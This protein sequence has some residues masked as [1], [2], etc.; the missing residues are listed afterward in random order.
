MM[1]RPPRIRQTRPHPPTSCL[2]CTGRAPRGR[3]LCHHV[4]VALTLGR[5]NEDATWW[6]ELAGTRVVFD[7]WL[8]GPEVD[9]APWFNR[10][11]HTGPV[12]PIEP[13]RPDLVVVSQHY[14]DH[15]HEETLRLLDASTVVAAVPTAAPTVTA[16]SPGRPVHRIPAWGEEP[17]ELHGLR[18][19]RLTRPWTRPPRYH[20]IVVADGNNQAVVHAPHGL[21]V[22]DAERLAPELTVEVLALTR[23][24]YQLPFFLGGR[25]NPGNDAAVAAA[26]AC[27]A[28]SV[29][30]IHD[31]PKAATGLVPRLAK[32][33][34]GP[35]PDDDL[36]W[37][38]VPVTP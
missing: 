37:L 35:W 36:H 14:A 34:R 16:L 13:C 38:E 18:L 24:T 11:V 8:V 21:S 27:G 7:P 31:E 29:L 10:A 6:V 20:A 32:V 28:R 22:A 5:L 9:F 1:N 15:C 17:L 12:L 4:E 2:W 30:A 25:V 33:D 23:I 3:E 19:W 26:R